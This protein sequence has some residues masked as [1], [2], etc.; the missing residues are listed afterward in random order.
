MVKSCPDNSDQ[1]EVIETSFNCFFD[2]KHSVGIILFTGK[3]YG[4]YVKERIFM[5]IEVPDDQARLHLQ[6]FQV[7]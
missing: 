5:R 3:D 4:F 1:H 6:V 7:L 2:R